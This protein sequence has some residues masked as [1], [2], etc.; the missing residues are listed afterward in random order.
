MRML[1]GKNLSE[2]TANLSTDYFTTEYTKSNVRREARIFIG[3][4]LDKYTTEPVFG[5][6]V[7]SLFVPSPPVR[8]TNSYY[9]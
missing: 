6:I 3:Y 4:I 9:F 5:K 8:I 1:S 2:K 7:L